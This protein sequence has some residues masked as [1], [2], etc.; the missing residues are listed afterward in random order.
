V[1]EARRVASGGWRSRTT[2]VLALSAAA[3]GLGNLWRFSYLAGEH[4]GGL[5]VLTYLAC[6][7]LIAVPVLIA[8]VALGSSGRA[9]PVLALGRAAQR[10]HR[11]P[12]WAAVGALACLTA[13]LISS[14][15]AVIGGWGLAYIHKMQSGFFAA[16]S[17]QV[18]AEHFTVFLDDPVQLI[19]WHGAFLVLAVTAVTLGV[20]QGLGVLAWLSVPAML[21][22]LGVLVDYALQHGDLEAGRAFLFS[23]SWQDFTA[24]AALAAL[25]QAF[26]TLGIG[27]GVGITYG[28][29]APAR[30]PVGRSVL[31]VALFD[32]VLA[33]GAGVAIF[34][35]LFANNVE[36]TLGPGLVFVSLP[37]SFANIAQG[38]LAGSLFFLL[39][40]VAAL[41]SVVAMLE[42]VTAWLIERSGWH[43]LLAA[44]VVGLVTWGLGLGSLLSFNVWS[45]V[46]WFGQWNLFELL[47]RVTADLLLPLVS[48]LLALF[49]G[50]G[51]R[52]PMLRA[53]LGRESP[54]FFSLWLVLLRYI[55]PAGI[56]AIMLSA[57][58]K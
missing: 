39:F 13:L 51:M 7:F 43:R 12:S 38:E 23:V 37:Y 10:A 33:L 1:I 44:P 48:L 40:V 27:V 28:A 17:A 35:I 22:L 47:Q 53:E 20:R 36:P 3:V 16:A 14:Y 5:F 30:I 21:V 31:A 45:G 9:N 52:R 57:L 6:L 2:F 8:E 50:W 24:E 46:D 41:A 19:Y 32:T 55:A 18:V 4:G 56:G 25:G 49:V 11:A 29:Y 15:Y 34:P 58:L 54:L 42:A 26:Y